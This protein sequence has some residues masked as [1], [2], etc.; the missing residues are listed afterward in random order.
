MR[1]RCTGAAGQPPCAP[2]RE[3]AQAQTSTHCVWGHPWTAESTDWTKAGSRQCQTCQSVAHR[4]WLAQQ[5]QAGPV[6]QGCLLGLAL[7][8]VCDYDGVAVV[9]G[10]G[11]SAW[12]SDAEDG[13]GGCVT[14]NG[15]RTGARTGRPGTRR[16]A[17]SAAPP[18]RHGGRRRGGSR[19]CGGRVQGFSRPSSSG[20]RRRG[21]GR[22][23]AS[24]AQRRAC[25]PCPSCAGT[26]GAWPR[27]GV[28]PGC[29]AVRWCRGSL[30][31]NAGRA[32]ARQTP[33]G[34]RRIPRPCAAPGHVP[35]RGDAA[36]QCRRRRRGPSHGAAAR[37]RG[38]WRRPSAGRAGITGGCAGWRAAIPAPHH[39][40]RSRAA[41]PATCRRSGNAAGA[42]WSGLEEKRRRRAHRRWR[43][44]RAVWRRAAQRARVSVRDSE[45]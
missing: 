16:I 9:A 4:R 5:R 38:F 29:P 13:P 43:S 22:V 12:L 34:G 27:P 45:V 28:K 32:G 23:P 6:R 35:G 37:Y 20:W 31:K 42:A 21:A 36:C 41:I 3:W 7:T 33:D 30:R 24:S 14:R 26:L 44:R 17:T 15:G 19:P 25:P 11:V 2:C 10:G 40:G 39:V 18:P 8:A 1:P